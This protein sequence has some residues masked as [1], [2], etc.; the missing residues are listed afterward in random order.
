MLPDVV[1]RSLLE[2]L[3]SIGDLPPG[4]HNIRKNGLC[5]SRQSVPGIEVRPKEDNPGIDVIV[6]AGIKN[7]VVYIPVLITA[8]GLHDIVYNTFEIGEEADVLLMA[9]CGVHNPGDRDSRHDGYHQVIVKKNARLQYVE[10]H[11]GEGSNGGARILNPKTTIILEEGAIAEMQLVQI[12]GVDS[13]VRVTEAVIR[14][15]ARLI[16]TERLLT[17]GSQLAESAITVRMTGRGASTRISAR[18][19]A[20]ENSEQR[21]RAL[22]VAEGASRGHVECDSIIMD[23]ARVSSSPGLSALNPEAE[24]THEAVIGKI[25]GD[26]LLKLMSLGLSEEEAREAILEGFLR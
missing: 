26:Q 9:G 19:V 13:T 20:Q 1:D 25:A 6:A 23:Q 21:F 14:A 2:T 17:H 3:C 10:R 12:R 11:Y 4:A 22:L 15:S 18:S 24:L 16:M 5:V 7:Q 8:T